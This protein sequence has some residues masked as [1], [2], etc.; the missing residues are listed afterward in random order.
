MGGRLDEI[1]HVTHVTDHR[2][3]AAGALRGPFVIMT[4]VAL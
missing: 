2:H 3:M 4:L 1:Y